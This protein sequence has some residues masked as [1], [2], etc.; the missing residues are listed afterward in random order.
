MK[1][2]IPTSENIAIAA[3]ALRAGDLVGM[4]TETVYGLAGDATN[5]DAVQ[6]IYATKDRPTNNPLIVHV[7]D[8]AS[9]EQLGTFNSAAR[10][11]V[12]VFWPGPVTI[13]TDI[14]KQEASN[15]KENS[16]ASCFL[17]LGTL[18]LRC[19]S[20]PVA[21]ALM[22]EFARPIAAPSANRSGQLSPTQANHVAESFSGLSQPKIILAGGHTDAGVE[23]TIVDCTNEIPKILR[24]GSVTLEDLQAVVP[25][26]QAYAPRILA[27]GE[28]PTAPGQLSRHYAPKTRVRLNAAEMFDGEV[29]LAFGPEPLWVRRAKFALNLSPSGD[30][31]EAAHN[32]FSYLHQLDGMNAA[33][34][35]VMPI[36]NTGLGAA[37]NDRLS[38]AAVR[39]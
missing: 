10:A 5:A 6:K 36:P 26:T 15:K 18:A 29:V 12:S 20:H 39:S 22:R 11:L 27:E 16:L 28:N 32:L 19:P 34:I 13:V 31:A 9:A 24:P 17:S 3:A 4:P 14:K 38:R 25:E 21:Q 8:L 2:L 7:P 35:A 1:I 23:S 37:L 30:L 33:A